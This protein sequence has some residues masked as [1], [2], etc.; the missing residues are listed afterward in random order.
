MPVR[1]L[2]SRVFR[3]PDRETVLS[4]AHRWAEGV[5]E[6]H[7]EVVRIVAFGSYAQG[8]H[9][10]GSDLDLLIEVSASATPYGERLP[11]VVDVGLPVPADILVFTTA[12]LSQMR[13]QGRRFAREVDAGI[14][15]WR[16]TP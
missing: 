8:R 2:R 5:G 1:S 15:L 16:R 12:E 4:A 6:R 13:A 9:G 14:E 3:W 11:P 7:A 10:V